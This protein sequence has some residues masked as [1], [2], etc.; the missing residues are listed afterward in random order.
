MTFEGSVAIAS[1][2]RQITAGYST[3]VRN[4]R[5]ELMAAK[6]HVP[7][8]SGSQPLSGEWVRLGR[9]ASAFDVVHDLLEQGGYGRIQNIWP[10]PSDT[11][12]LP[13]QPNVADPDGS[14]GVTVF[15]TMAGMLNEAGT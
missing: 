15:N 9:P 7:V 4:Y 3:R 14:N 11:S 1:Y 10:G 5:R 13:A 2:D 6:L 12:V 8:P